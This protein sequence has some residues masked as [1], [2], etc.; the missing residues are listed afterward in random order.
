MSDVAS[1]ILKNCDASLPS[2]LTESSQT[3]TEL[4]NRSDFSMMKVRTP[5]SW[6]K[7]F[8]ILRIRACWRSIYLLGRGEGWL[9]GTAG[10]NRWLIPPLAVT[11]AHPHAQPSHSLSFPLLPSPLCLPLSL[12]GSASGTCTHGRR[13]KP[14]SGPSSSRT[15]HCPTTPS[16]LRASP[17][18]NSRVT[19]WSKC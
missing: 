9:M 1:N 5:Q 15:R 12:F 16:S 11:P 13:S 14:P 2:I 6:A 7:F 3:A 19:P 17:S 8:S 18:F 4:L 10:W